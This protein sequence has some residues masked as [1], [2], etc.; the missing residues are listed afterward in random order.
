M[1]DH[2]VHIGEGFWNI[3]GSFKL[4]GFVEIGTQASLVRLDS[5]KFVLLDS[6]ELTGAVEREVMSLTADG[7]DVEAVI[8]THPFHTVHCE[9]TARQFPQAKHYGTRRH[10]EKYPSLNWEPEWSESEALHHRYAD[11]LRFSVPRGVEFI[12]DNQNLHFASV[13]VFHPRSRSLHVD[14]TLGYMKLPVLGGSVAFHPTLKWVLEKRFGAVTD[15]R[16][17]AEGL[18]EQCADVDHLCTAHGRELPPPPQAGQSVRD[19]V[20]AAYEKIRKTLDAHQRTYG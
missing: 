9:A 10:I 11:D 15:F 3:R 13:L 19:Q 5:G 8:N 18:I 6:Y 2:I 16:D 17:W 4:F 7:N 12:P 1:S 14:D 20:R